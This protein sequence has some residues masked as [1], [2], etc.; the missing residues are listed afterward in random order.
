MES[1][2]FVEPTLRGFFSAWAIDIKEKGIEAFCKAIDI[3][4]KR[5]E[6]M[7]S[8]SDEGEKVTPWKKT[9][10]SWYFQLIWE[11]AVLGSALA[12]YKSH[13]FMPQ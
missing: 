9:V 1:A 13:I 12:A 8:R 6:F 5:I 4:G 3:L 7:P 2:R 10:P 11:K